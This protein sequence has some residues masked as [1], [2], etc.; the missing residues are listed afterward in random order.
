MEIDAVS[1]SAGWRYQLQTYDG[2]ISMN[3]A[4]LRHDILCL[5][6][7]TMRCTNLAIWIEGGMYMENRCC[8]RLCRM[9]LPGY[10]LMMVISVLIM[11]V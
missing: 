2:H 7:G 8:Q 4:S 10:K 9:A 3:N 1:G 5:Y 6:I 11:R